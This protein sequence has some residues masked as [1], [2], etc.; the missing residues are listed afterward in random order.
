MYYLPKIFPAVM[1]TALLLLAL[2][3]Y[4]QTPVSTVE[5]ANAANSCNSFK[6]NQLPFYPVT[7]GI[8]KI[9]TAD[10]DHDGIND[11]IVNQS[12]SGKLAVQLGDGEGGI[13]ETKYSA[14]GGTGALD[15]DLGDFNR[16]G[17][18]DAI[19]INTESNKLLLLLGD[20]TGNFNL[21]NAFA[22]S[23]SSPQVVTAGYF[24]ADNYLDVAV[25]FSDSLQI[26]KGNRDST[27]TLSSIAGSISNPK[28]I[29]SGDFNKDGRNDLVVAYDNYSSSDVRLYLNQGG[30]FSLTN[31]I[32][33]L[34]TYSL[35]AI[36]VNKDGN[37]DLIASDLQTAK[38]LTY[39][40]NGS[41][42]FGSPVI[43]DTGT[44]ATFETLDFN[45]DGKT[46][47]V[48]SGGGVLLGD[49]S[50][51]F[52]YY[53]PAVVR[54]VFAGVVTADFNS[55]GILDFGI[56]NVDLGSGTSILL[57]QTD[58]PVSSPAVGV[59]DRVYEADSADF[60][61][62][63]RNDLVTVSPYNNSAHVIL[64]DSQGKF[65][66]VSG[67]FG[68]SIGGGYNVSAG[69]VVV[70]DF[71]NDNKPDFAA[72]DTYAG[73]VAVFTG[74][75][76]GTFVK[77][78][79]NLAATYVRPTFIRTGDF[80]RDGKLDIITTNLEGRDFSVLLNDGAGGFTFVPGVNIN[81]DS[82]T[83]VLAVGDITNDGILDLIVVRP[84]LGDFIF[85][86]GNG[87]GTFVRNPLLQGGVGVPAALIL[88]DLNND[89]NLDL[90]IGGNSKIKV[91][92][93]VG[94]GGF[95]NDVSYPLNGYVSDL[96]LQDFDLDGTKDI[97]ASAQNGSLIFF[98]G[99]ADG[100]F[101]Q[102]QTIAVGIQP[103]SL[104][105][106]DFNNDGKPDIATAAGYGGIKVFYNGT[107]ISKC[108]SIG[109]AQV[110]EGDTGTTSVNFTVTLAAAATEAVSVDYQT[111]SRTAT[112]GTDFV[113]KSG[114]L[115]FPA[116]T[117]SQTVS[118]EIKGDNLP[119]NDE[120]FALSLSNPL[121][122]TLADPVGTAKIVDDDTFVPSLSIGNATVVEGSGGSTT[123]YL[124]VNLSGVSGKRVKIQVTTSDVSA[125]SNQDYQPLAESFY[126]EPGETSKSLAIEI[127]P[128]YRVEPDE[129]FSVGLSNPS[130]A[131]LANN[132]ATVTITDDDAGG[133]IQFSDA[134]L[135]VSENVGSVRITISRANGTASDVGFK[136][137]T[138][139]GT[140]TEFE[141]YAPISGTLFFGANETSKIVS[142]PIINDALNENTETFSIV[143]ENA[144]GGA[145]L[146]AQA[147]ITVSILDNDPT[148][149]RLSASDL[150][151]TEGNYGIKTVNYQ[152]RLLTASGR[153]VSVG[154]TTQNGTATA[155]E[156]YTASS[157]TLVFA[158][159]ET[160]KII[161]LNI[162]SDRNQ[163][164]DETFRVILS[165]PVNAEINGVGSSGGITILNDDSA[166][167]RRPAMDFDGDGK[168]DI[169]VYRPSNGTWYLNQSQNGLTGVKFGETDDKIVPAD[170]DGDGKTDLAV[171]R[172]GTWYL[173]R[174]AQGF[175][176]IQFGNASDVPQPADFNGDGKA[177]LAVYRPANGT[178][179]VYY[180]AT[181]PFSAYQFGANADKPV[182]GDYDGDGKADYAV[183]R[184]GVWYIQG[185]EIGFVGMQFGAAQDKAVP[186]DY[187]GDGRIDLAVFR[188]SNGTWY[189]QNSLSGF[190]ATQFGAA[191]DLPTPADYDGD[192]KADVAVYRSGTW[193]IQQ[194]ANG[195]TGFQFGLASDKPLP[196]AFIF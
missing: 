108:L 43:S 38:L 152:V 88:S 128:D 40:G 10:L 37:L 78:V 132:Q 115:V 133:T 53:L 160:S 100:A 173:L 151:V 183:Y 18:L 12:Y 6:I 150:S 148:L 107:N 58:R 114:T 8:N 184:A 32:P 138:V 123:A 75:G 182:V 22:L 89:G 178:W 1:A 97:I 101:E 47:L 137:K 118:V 122:A 176:G 141:D 69:A 147:N 76:D 3:F 13:K 50:G 139:A 161:P 169:S 9:K 96:E 113:S 60:N 15:F 195:F 90:V 44:I 28:K 168:A 156:D 63:G 31:I 131:G 155:P 35:A 177:E 91:S 136:V 41:G 164:P 170:Y 166:T 140:A 73:K 167:T 92:Y 111:V 48:T 29:V 162:V 189:F 181:T 154:Y 143:L 11:L 64:Q 86:V 51:K 57:N 56:V 149:P 54:G 188:P 153:Q 26:F 124:P 125:V 19:V 93:G 110:N 34:Q 112:A 65:S 159:G 135:S 16:D 84:T 142:I 145:T 172:N 106:K 2:P 85:L 20:G 27:F 99:L 49:D 45:G 17:E 185:S 102:A 175:T 119:E 79:F 14:A 70:G 33:N 126:L 72:P 5:S 104:T 117:T 98:K 121:N 61:G 95:F 120:T 67:P 194:S 87:D 39:F 127:N 55:D 192:G 190:S 36:D 23:G 174:S 191:G 46:D 196:G 180:S 59:Y 7:D 82:T 94:N 80:N 109:D 193:Y 62:D 179:Y 146:G 30:N 66:D 52:N 165:N 116:G 187:D 81:P 171:Y 157:G 4:S 144:T 83:S 21:S 129:T 77:A 74:N 42:G 24:D 105:S 163:E 68:L 103:F 186:A 25:A 158:P 134:S 71:N 130:N